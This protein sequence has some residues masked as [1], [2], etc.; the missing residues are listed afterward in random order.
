MPAKVILRSDFDALQL[1]QFANR[2]SDTR[3][4]CRLL[5]L[6]AV[7]DGMSRGEAAKVGGMDR[8]TLRDWVHRFND[9]GPDGLVN[10]RGPKRKRRLSEA[11]LQALAEIV[12]TGPDPEV[13][14]VVRWRRVDL[15][16][17]IEKRFKVVYCERTISKLLA[18]LGFSHISARPQH[19]GQDEAVMA[20]FKKTSPIRLRPTPQIFLPVK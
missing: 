15:Q 4:T 13:D 17:L 2:S 3:Q 12:E 9:L 5:A 7:Y 20:A 11:Q 8:Q 19:P 18:S 6:A 10:S 14:G 16:R 1:R